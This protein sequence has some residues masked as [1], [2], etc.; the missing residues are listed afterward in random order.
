M[1]RLLAFAVLLVVPFAGSAAPVP[2][3]LKAKKVPSVE[4]TTWVGEH[5]VSDL[6]RIDYTF[7]PEGK[8]T[9]RYPNGTV[10]TKGSWRQ[11]GEELYLEMNNRYAEYTV[12]YRDGRFEGDAKNV[13]GKAWRLTL[14]KPD[15]K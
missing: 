4:G 10:Y 8:L 9:Y 7:L 2:K 14:T 6:N 5:T 3:A 11:D 12:T 13:V 1:T 15:G